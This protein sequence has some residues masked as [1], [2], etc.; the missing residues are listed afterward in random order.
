MLLDTCILIPKL[1]VRWSLLVNAT[2]RLLYALEVT[3]VPSVKVLWT[4][5][6]DRTG[7]EKRQIYC[8]PEFETHI[9]QSVAGRCTDYTI[10][11]LKCKFREKFRIFV[12]KRDSTVLVNIR[13]V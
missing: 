3:P 2:L 4:P 5:R 7:M 9:L 8:R 12:V 13:I 1:G 11:S 10:P 6:L